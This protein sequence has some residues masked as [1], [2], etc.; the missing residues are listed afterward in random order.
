[1]KNFNL[2][3]AGLRELSD[4]ELVETEGGLIW[5][6]AVA[7]LVLLSSCEN[8]TNVNTGSG[9]QSNVQGT[10][11]TYDSCSVTNVNTEVSVKVK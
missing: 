1:M 11:N 7:A 2:Q 4:E 5:F 6:V 8:Q 10:S 3:N 9:T